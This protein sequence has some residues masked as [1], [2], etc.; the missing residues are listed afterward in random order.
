MT[1]AEELID[2]GISSM[3]TEAYGDAVDD[4]DQALSRLTEAKQWAEKSDLAE[5]WEL[6]QR[7][8]IVREYRSDAESSLKDHHESLRSEIARR[9]DRA[10]QLVS[11]GRQQLELEDATAANES[12]MTA[13]DL[14]D[15][16]Q[17]LLND[18]ELSITAAMDRRSRRIKHSLSEL[19]DNLD[20]SG[21]EVTGVSRG[22]LV[23]ALQRLAVQ[24][25][26]SPR[27]EFV[28]ACGS[29][30]SSEYIDTFG[31]WERALQVA[32]L[33]PIDWSARDRRK[34][35]RVDILES[36]EEVS[37]ELGRP[38]TKSEMGKFGSVSVTTVLKRFTSWETATELA[39]CLET[40]SETSGDSWK[41][42]LTAIAGVS[43]VEAQTLYN[44][45]F[46][47][48]SDVRQA[49]LEELTEV[50]GIPKA[51]ALRMKADVGGVDPPAE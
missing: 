14:L 37:K 21:H 16:V 2:E 30:P 43:E 34:Y 27:T 15:T 47:S 12:Y 5:Q 39:D 6:E 36:I 3:D 40:D 26:E 10:E 35:T 24:T 17:Q 11:M 1:D 20:E 28:D 4:F 8:R 25:R 31:S 50:D 38:P 23:D 48:T 46:E 7:I 45:G 32:N 49:T 19:Q 42:T 51:L 33:E 22:N 18:S 29:Y 13:R 41:T 44:A 9:L